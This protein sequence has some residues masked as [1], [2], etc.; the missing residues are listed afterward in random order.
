MKKILIFCLGMMF[1]LTSCTKVSSDEKNAVDTHK[2]EQQ[3]EQQKEEKEQETEE[4]E[5]GIKE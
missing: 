1:L 3:E 4:I 2:A 5:P